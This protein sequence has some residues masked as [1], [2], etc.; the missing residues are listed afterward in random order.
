LLFPLGLAP[1]QWDAAIAA[2]SDRFTTVR[3]GGRHIGFVQML[4]E[5]ATEGTYI[6][7]VRMMFDLLNIRPGDRVLEVGTGTG[8]LARD[9]AG[10]RYAPAE[11]LG[12]DVNEFLLDEA[13]F[14]GPEQSLNSTLRFQYGDAE[15]LPFEDSTFDVAFAATVFEECNVE[16]GIA[17]L[18]RVLK[19]DGR[20]G[21]I[22]RSADL[23]RHWNLDMAETVSRKV[24]TVFRES[25]G[26]TGCVDG[27]IYGRFAQRFTEVA[28]N[29]FWR[30]LTEIPEATLAQTRA[31]L[32]AGEEREF[33]RALEAGRAAGTAFVAT[34]FHC[35][36][37]VKG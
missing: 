30:C 11:V 37:G 14:L 10:G 5:R 32:N 25:V 16:K 15:A 4:E 7:G 35:V 9:L 18:H 17:E 26:A 28:A 1:T 12:V 20:A 6:Q 24:N 13:R 23:P 3:L 22:V 27:S 21:V 36:V 2:L 34:P 31:L 8:A 29:P 33:A 19:P